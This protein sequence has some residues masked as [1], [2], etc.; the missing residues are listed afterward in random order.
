M[1][2]SVRLHPR[3]PGGEVTSSNPLPQLI[4]TPSG[5]AILELQGTINLPENHENG[6]GISQEIA[7][8]RL[9]FP[10]YHPETQDPSSTY[11]MKRVHLYVGEHQRL[12]GE[13]K[14]LPKAMA[15]IKKRAS[16]EEDVDMNEG[17][18][19]T[20]TEDL[21]VVEIV[22]YKIVFSQRPEPVGT[23]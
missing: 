12:T 23:G 7:V 18:S 6:E 13:V 11:W 1:A 14:K 15:I 22:K 9:V 20:T 4:Q 16:P 2:S 8:G 10:D 17:N 19:E 5:L 3:K 21:E